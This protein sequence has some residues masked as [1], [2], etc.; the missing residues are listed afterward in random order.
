MHNDYVIQTV[1][2]HQVDERVARAAEA[3]RNR[4]SRRTRPDSG[5][6]RLP[7]HTVFARIAAIRIA[8]SH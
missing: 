5:V 4:A 8:V 2:R 1:A 6:P 3:R 7:A